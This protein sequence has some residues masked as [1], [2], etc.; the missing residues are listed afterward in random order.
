M[1][2]AMASWR[3]RTEALR[4]NVVASPERGS[5][6]EVGCGADTSR[7]RTRLARRGELTHRRTARPSRSRERS[8]LCSAVS[9]QVWL[10][11]T[12]TRE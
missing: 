4:S 11:Q 7:R 10:T 12:S 1:S 9:V 2:L 8:A 6:V 3:A 5:M